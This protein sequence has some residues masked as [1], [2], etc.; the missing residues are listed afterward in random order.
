MLKLLT[1]LGP[2]VIFCTVQAFAGKIEIIQLNERNEAISS[3]GEF[4]VNNYYLN[5]REELVIM[6]YASGMCKI[7]LKLLGSID[8][9]A[10]GSDLVNASSNTKL[11][12]VVKNK[13]IVDG[14]SVTATSFSIAGKHDHK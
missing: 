4:Q 8:P 7:P 10:L 14:W 1:I 13:K 12:C 2:I 3:S 6:G 11:S 9:R 5:S